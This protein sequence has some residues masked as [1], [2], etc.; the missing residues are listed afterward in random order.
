[1]NIRVPLTLGI[2]NGSYI[3]T[4]AWGDANGDGN[5]ENN[6]NKDDLKK[7][8][9]GNFYAE[10]ENSLP[11]AVGVKLNLLDITHSPLLSIPQNGSSIAVVSGSVDGAGNVILAAHSSA[12]IQLNNADVQ[13]FIPA[14]F[15]RFVVSLNTAGGGG[16][17]SLHTTD[18]IRIRFW[19]NMSFKVAK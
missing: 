17:V 12:V 9:F 6:I 15:I 11:V 8:N 13:Q 19:S 4:L 1:M 10:V 16:A 2:T 5:K 7:V 14:E 18:S 3:D